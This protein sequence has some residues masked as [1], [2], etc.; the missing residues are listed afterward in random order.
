MTIDSTP[1]AHDDGGTGPAVMLLHAGIA[2]RRMWRGQV[3]ALQAAGYRTITPDL[4]GYGESTL[5]DA[6]FAHHD[7]V[8]DL[9]DHLGIAHATVVGCSFGGRVTLDLTLAHPDRVDGL[10]LFGAA[11]GGHTWSPELDEVWE[12]VT[13]NPDSDDV[14]AVAAAEVRFWVVA[15]TGNPAPSTRSCCGSRPR[16]TWPPWPAR[17]CWTPPTSGTWNRP[18]WAGSARSPC[19]HW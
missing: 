15:R 2:D 12:R 7:R 10:A 16:W 19:R 5:P 8:V 9:L 11:V 18:P 1:L 17:R 13:G 6:P 4:T 3:P 14:P